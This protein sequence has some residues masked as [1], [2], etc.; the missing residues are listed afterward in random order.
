MTGGGNV[1]PVDEDYH[2][3]ERHDQKAMD[4]K[5]PGAKFSSNILSRAFDDNRSVGSGKSRHPLLVALFFQNAVGKVVASI[6]ESSLSGNY[7]LCDK[8]WSVSALGCR[9]VGFIGK[10]GQNPKLV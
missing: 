6:G 1:V 7:P 4:S 5:Q 10:H 8:P 9:E 2:P 3:E